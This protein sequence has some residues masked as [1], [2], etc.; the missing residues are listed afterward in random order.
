[1]LQFNRLF[2]SA[3]NYQVT[4]LYAGTD[5]TYSRKSPHITQVR[6]QLHPQILTFSL[7]NSPI[8]APV[9]LAFDDPIGNVKNFD[10]ANCFQQFLTQP[11]PFD[12]IHFHNLEGLTANCLKLAKESRAKVLFSLHNYWA[13][14]PQ[15]NLWQLESSPCSN[16]LEGR[17]C[18]SCMPEKVD[19]N[20]EIG[21]K[22]LNHLGS[23]IG[24]HEYTFGLR[25]I[26]KYYTRFYRRRVKN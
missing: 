23:A 10:L 14:C 7:F 17:T 1:M 20:L 26:K 25:L 16:Y 5:Y 2:N 6:N 13:V 18:V 21:L 15:V 24:Q 3:K 22:K 11:Q 8:P 12:I 4:C 19:L 9:Y